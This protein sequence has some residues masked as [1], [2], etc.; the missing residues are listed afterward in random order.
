MRTTSSEAYEAVHKSGLINRTRLRVYDTIYNAD[1]P[2]SQSEVEQAIALTTGSKRV[3]SYHK[4]FSELERLGVIAPAGE[5]TCRVTGRNVMTWDVTSNAPTPPAKKESWRTMYERAR[6]ENEALR[7]DV[8]RLKSAPNASAQIEGMTVKRSVNE[9]V[10]Q[11]IDKVG[12]G[13]PMEGALQETIFD[14]VAAFRNADVVL[15]TDVPKRYETFEDVRRN[16]A[17]VQAIMDRDGIISWAGIHLCVIALANENEFL[18]DRCIRLD[19]VVPKRI[20]VNG[21][22]MVWHCPDDIVPSAP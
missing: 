5:R 21:Q 11:I 10:A 16:V 15:A 4:R 22:T 1:G 14:I 19:R 6:R 13:K 18:R 17:C 20:T 12:N 9:Y 8:E 3:T 2:M 7:A